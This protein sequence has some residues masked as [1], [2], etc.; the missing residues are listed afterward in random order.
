MQKG[1]IGKSIAA[2]FCI[3][4]GGLIYLMCDNAFLGAFLFGFGLI[5][6]CA[7]ELRF[8]TFDCFR[9]I[10]DENKK[11]PGKTLELVTQWICNLI[12]AGLCGLIAVYDPDVH[13]KA[14]QMLQ[15]KNE[16]FLDVLAPSILGGIVLCMCVEIY[17]R[18]AS[19]LGVILGAPILML[20]GF[21]DCIINMF[22]LSAAIDYS[23][24]MLVISALVGN[25]IGGFAA[26][27]TVKQYDKQNGKRMHI[28]S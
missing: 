13:I 9:V 18:R 7:L 1:L 22:Y 16:S 10:A 24:I 27:I 5:A 8:Y 26:Y 15:A 3:G 28:K 17:R 11:I 20:C 23:K 25:T 12:G 4:I 2:G 6:I 21:D 14:T 19:F